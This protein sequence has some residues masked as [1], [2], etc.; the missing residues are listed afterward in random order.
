MTIPKNINKEHVIEAIQKIDRE[1]VPERRESTRFNLIY[2]GKYY[3][4]K[5]CYFNCKHFCKW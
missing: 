4:P 3:P 2:E 5:V 1:G